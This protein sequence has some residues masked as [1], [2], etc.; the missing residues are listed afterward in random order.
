MTFFDY[1]Y[2]RV[3]APEDGH[4]PA[5]LLQGRRLRTNVPE[6]RTELGYPIA[7]R[8]QEA[9]GNT[10]HPLQQGDIE[11][12]PDDSWSQEARVLQEVAFRSRIAAKD[13]GRS[14]RRSWQHLLQTQEGYH[15]I[16]EDFNG[17]S[18][19]SLQSE[20]PRLLQHGPSAPGF[21]GHPLD[22]AHDFSHC[23]ASQAEHRR[24]TRQR[25]EPQRL[26]YDAKFR[27]VS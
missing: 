13:D 24:L 6:H 1:E 3:S 12:V 26:Q 16:D 19:N 18:G 23:E 5:Q 4:S 11:L 7:K 2:Y 20:R 10:L 9:M 27:Q 25:K 21:S 17:T 14:L 15:R 22:H 8:Q